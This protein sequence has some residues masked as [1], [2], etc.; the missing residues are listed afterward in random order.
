MKARRQDPMT[1]PQR[2]AGDTPGFT[3]RR[4]AA[5]V[6]DGVS[7]WCRSFDDGLEAAAARAAFSGLAKRDRA[8]VRA[9]T[10]TAMRRLVTL[11]HLIGRSLDAGLPAQAPRVETALIVGAA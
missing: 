1:P 9:L 4:M 10:A 5:D 3:A 8:L 6:L 11:R 7:R 2:P